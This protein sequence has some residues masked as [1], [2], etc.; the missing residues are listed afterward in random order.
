MRVSTYCP[1][2]VAAISAKLVGLTIVVRF[3]SSRSFS[4]SCSEDSHHFSSFKSRDSSR[5]C[6]L[7]WIANNLRRFVVTPTI[8]A[9]WYAE[10]LRHTIIF[11]CLSQGARAL[12]E[13]FSC[14]GRSLRLLTGTHFGHT[15]RSAAASGVSSI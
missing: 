3:H 12:F 2:H 13:A 11:T 5:M 15:A 1:E 7:T 4:S 10:R 6:L 9:P 8:T 14:S